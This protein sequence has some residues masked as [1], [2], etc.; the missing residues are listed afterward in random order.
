VLEDYDCEQGAAQEFCQRF[1]D[2]LNRIP[3]TAKDTLYSYWLKG[4][5]SP[6]VWLLA[7]RSELKNWQGWAAS[8]SDG[9]S[10][11]FLSTLLQRI[12]PSHIELAIAHE[13]GHALLIAAEEPHHCAGSIGPGWQFHPLCEDKRLVQKREWLV[14]QLMDAWG[15]DQKAAEVWM[16]QHTLEGEDGA[17]LRADPLSDAELTCVALRE[18]MESELSDMTFPEEFKKYL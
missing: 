3:A 4:C 13:F 6:H 10:F 9:L 5:G 17:Q 18:K 2:I 12:P 15:F 1:A 11:Y 7:D 14:W 16:E 8:S